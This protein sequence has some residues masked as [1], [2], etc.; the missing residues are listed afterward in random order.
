MGTVNVNKVIDESKL[1]GYHILILILCAIAITT[2]GY[3]LVVFGT[4]VPVMM[5]EWNLTPVQAGSLSSYALI[6]MMLGALFFGSLA[7]KIGRKKVVIICVAIFGVFNG[8]CSFANGPG[9]F[10]IYRF[11]AGL[12]LGGVM[13]IVTTMVTEFSPKKVRSIFVTI[14]FSGM[15]LGPMIAAGLGI[16]VIPSVGWRA[17]FWLSAVPLLAIPFFI[18]YLPES[19]NVYLA[20]N[21]DEKIRKTL[22][23]LNKEY[24]PEEEEKYM[25]GAP[26]LKGNAVAS[27]FENK[28]SLST[29]MFWSVFFMSLLTTYALQTWL[30][31]LMQTGGYSMGS[32]LWFM[33]I[34]NF[35][36]IAGAIFGGILLDRIN[37]RKVIIAYYLVAVLCFFLLS[38]KANMVILSLLILIVGGTTMGT[39]IICNAYVS[40]YYPITMRASAMGWALGI[41]R[42]GGILGPLIMGSLL[43]M[44]FSLQQNFMVIAIPSLIAACG[45][46]FVQEKYS[47]ASTLTVSRPKSET[48]G[49]ETF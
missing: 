33:L 28:R 1:N 29:I 32:S 8:L 43:G 12:G 48:G 5:K 24:K 7:D 47:Y 25:L 31:K 30:P 15:Q 20:R 18:A 38:F 27:L 34:L 21:D 23:K 17:M 22:M 39:Q 2:D 49:K 45:M 9:V 37:G 10:G 26:K 35:G 36:A 42:I 6:G 3:G 13:P 41:G 40:Q 44:G 16:I 4:V 14:M 46:I 11:I 19:M